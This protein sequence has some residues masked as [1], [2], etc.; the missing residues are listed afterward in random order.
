MCREVLQEPAGAGAEAVMGAHIVHYD[1]P[2]EVPPHPAPSPD[3]PD[4]PTP[5]R[6]HESCLV[7]CRSGGVVEEVA[8]AAAAEAQVTAAWEPWQSFVWQGSLSTN[9]EQKSVFRR[10]WTHE[11]CAMTCFQPLEGRRNML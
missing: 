4:S 10:A 2:F 1:E 8:A 5:G 7:H 11:L 6:V 3:S 9:L